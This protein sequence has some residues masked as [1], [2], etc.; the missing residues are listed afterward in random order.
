MTLI[1]LLFVG[2]RDNAN[3]STL[4][5]LFKLILDPETSPSAGCTNSYKSSWGG[6]SK[7]RSHEK[8]PVWMEWILAHCLSA[9]CLCSPPH[10]N[11]VSFLCCFLS[12]C[13]ISSHLRISTYTQHFPPSSLCL[14]VLSPGTLS[15]PVF[16]CTDLPF[17][18]YWMKALLPLG[19]LSI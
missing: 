18:S 6:I 7:L 9:H 13:T 2:N 8:S 19:R 11:P 17:G 5:F 14:P 4:S 15:L 1:F 16:E 3:S 12:Q 10:F